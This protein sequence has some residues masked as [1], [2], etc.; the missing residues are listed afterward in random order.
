MLG[1]ASSKHVLVQSRTALVVQR[2]DNQLTIKVA[3]HDFLQPWAPMRVEDQAVFKRCI[4]TLINRGLYSHKEPH[5]RNDREEI[6]NV[7][8]SWSNSI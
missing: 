8:K 6:N 4:A 7:A 1:I 2:Q 3:A 5:V